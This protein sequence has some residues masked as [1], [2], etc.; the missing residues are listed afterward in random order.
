MAL[1]I[2]WQPGHDLNK[3]LLALVTWK[4]KTN[5]GHNVQIYPLK[6][7]VRA[8]LNSTV[9]FKRASPFPTFKHEI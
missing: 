4:S 5:T 9:Y 2:A 3:H 8:S 6:I 7:A 1:H